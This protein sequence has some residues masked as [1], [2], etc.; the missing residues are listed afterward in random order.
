MQ[1]V[2]FWTWDITFH[3]ISV[4]EEI[5]TWQYENDDAIMQCNGE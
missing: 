5:M 3:T 1:E 4:F 2:I